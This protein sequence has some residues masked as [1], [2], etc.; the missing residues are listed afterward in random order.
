MQGYIG[1][2]AYVHRVTF[3]DVPSVTMGSFGITR[4]PGTGAVIRY[5]GLG[6]QGDDEKSLNAKLSR[7]WGIDN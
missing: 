7:H 2:W 5:L 1:T 6:T 4:Y 3:S